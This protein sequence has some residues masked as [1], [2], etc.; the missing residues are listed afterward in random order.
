[1]A[2]LILFALLLGQAA[3]P[4]PAPP[5]AA[6]AP[7]PTAWPFSRFTAD[8]YP[9]AALRAQEQ[10]RVVY[11]ITIGTEGRVSGCEVRISSGSA[12]LDA[13]TCRIVRSRARF[14]PARD[15]EGRPVPDRRDGNVLWRLPGANGE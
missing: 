12:A 15:S 2:S 7:P 9:A 11:R 6:P 10:G 13:A 4:A 14:T 8:D 3:A 5:A 1:M